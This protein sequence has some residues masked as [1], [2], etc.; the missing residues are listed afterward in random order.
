MGEW[1]LPRSPVQ[2][3]GRELLEELLGAPTF[4]SG[5]RWWGRQACLA[6]PSEPLLPAGV[7]GILATELFDQT[8]RP[9]AYMVCGVLM[10]T[11]LFVVGLGF[12]FI[13][14]GLPEVLSP[15]AARGGSIQGV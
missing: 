11:M 14:V 8:T 10:W 9:A 6:A 13:M 3:S 15:S 2:A 5:A 1:P 4:L 12:P 7:T